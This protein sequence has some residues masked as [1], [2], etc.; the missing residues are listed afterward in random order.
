[1]RKQQIL[2]EAIESALLE[3]GIVRNGERIYGTRTIEKLPDGKKHEYEVFPP[4]FKDDKWKK[5]VE[6]FEAS[7][8]TYNNNL[9][10]NHDNLQ[11]V[12][13]SAYKALNGALRVGTI[14]RISAGKVD[15]ALHFVNSLL[16][17]AS[18][19]ILLSHSLKNDVFGEKIWRGV[20]E[21]N[22]DKKATIE[23]L[24]KELEKF[25]DIFTRHF[26]TLLKNLKNIE[27][28]AHLI[29]TERGHKNDVD[30][31]IAK[32]KSQM[33]EALKFLKEDFQKIIKNAIKAA[34]KTTKI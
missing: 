21:E 6:K 12:L 27:E 33:E 34:K 29:P 19:P 1:M 32:R 28:N 5:E 30:A 3:Y 7:L 11:E 16:G 8:K 14:S 15:K 22:E 10:K 25:A 26:E 17:V 23:D 9:K 20:V 2:K 24:E 18:Q 13:N 4:H 31:I